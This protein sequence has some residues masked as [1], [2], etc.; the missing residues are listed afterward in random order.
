M[1]VRWASDVRR[2]GISEE[3]TNMFYISSNEILGF[4]KKNF[5][6]FSLWVFGGLLGEFLG[7]IQG[8]GTWG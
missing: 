6:M 3:K 1:A 8:L 4:S 5:Y 7:F 2:H